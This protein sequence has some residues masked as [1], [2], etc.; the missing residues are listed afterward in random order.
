MYGGAYWDDANAITP[1]PDGNFIVAGNT[2]SFGKGGFDVYLLKVNSGGDTLWTRTYGGKGDD[3]ATAIISTQDGNFII[4]G[5]TVTPG[6]TMQDVYLLKIKPNGDTIWTKTY[7]GGFAYAISTTQDGNIIVAGYLAIHGVTGVTN[8]FIYILKIKSNGDTLWTRSFMGPYC[9]ICS[10]TP[11]SEGNFIVAGNTCFYDTG[12]TSS[13]DI[14]LLKITTLGDT[15]WIKTYGGVCDDYARAITP[16]PDGNFI[17]A[18]FSI[19]NG[20]GNEY[21]YILK[22]KP[23]GDTLWIKTY[24]GTNNYAGAY[25]ITPTADG[26]FIVAGSALGAGNND[27]YLLKIKPDGDTIWTKTFGGT[28]NEVFNTL[29]PTSDGNFIVAGGIQNASEE[30]NDILLFSLTDDRYAYKNLPFTFKIPVYDTD[31]L[32]HGYTP[33]KTPAGMT[34]SLGGTISW[35]PK[36]DSVYMD[37]VEFLVSD[38]MGKKDTLSF[39]I[40]VNTNH[41][42]K[43]TNPLSLQ[44]QS[45]LTNE[46]SVRNISPKE[47]RF[48]LPA[49]SKSL[50][51]YDVRGQ[52]LEKISVI[53]NSATWRPKHAAGR[54]FAKAIWEKHETVKPFIILR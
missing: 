31:S 28:C 49:G 12:G 2:V 9:D 44:R 20:D 27:A 54:F 50:G 51:I 14:Y 25:A 7:S 37:H 29:A 19:C 15:L 13:H 18:G 10:I 16:T 6:T 36:T 8:D 21:V 33:L 3:F 1:T 39:N 26:N 23:N 38:D 46:I 40:F 53:R 30:G 32:N 5:G 41:I 22:I 42:S 45:P 52:L 17:V 43:A 47:V 24:G 35:T 34:V 11:T 4:A 48:S